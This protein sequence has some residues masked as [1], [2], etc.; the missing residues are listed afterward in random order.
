MNTTI[1]YSVPIRAPRRRLLKI[2]GFFI[3]ELENMPHEDQVL[4]I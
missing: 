1:G 3:V 4:A 2:P